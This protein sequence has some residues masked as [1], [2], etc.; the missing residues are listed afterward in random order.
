MACHLMSA[1]NDRNTE[2]ANLM[3]GATIS[4]IYKSLDCRPWIA[5]MNDVRLKKTVGSINRKNNLKAL[6]KASQ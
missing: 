6:K 3:R 5:M 4:R 1:V 2:E